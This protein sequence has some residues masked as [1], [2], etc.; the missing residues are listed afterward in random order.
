[1]SNET[2]CVTVESADCD[3]V[4]FFSETSFCILTSKDAILREWTV[5]TP[6]RV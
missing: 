5:G 6:C 1:M 4:Q 3:S 2:R